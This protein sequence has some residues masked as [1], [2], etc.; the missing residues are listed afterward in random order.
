MLHFV[1]FLVKHILIQIDSWHD[2]PQLLYE[3]INKIIKDSFS[4]IDLHNIQ[5]QHNID[6]WYHQ[7]KLHNK[8]FQMLLTIVYFWS[9]HIEKI[10]M[11]KMYF[12]NHKN[13]WVR[14]QQ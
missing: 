14:I 1:H 7:G 5:A 13:V 3:T 2:S 4:K 10:I 9:C 8:Q 11:D 6:N 12:C